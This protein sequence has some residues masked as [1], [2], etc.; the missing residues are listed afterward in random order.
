MT[1]NYPSDESC[2]RCGA[3]YLP[4]AAHQ[5][6]ASKIRAVQAETH[7]SKDEDEEVDEFGRIIHKQKNKDQ[8]PEWPP[9]FE[10]SG[11]VF[12]FD[13]RSGM[14]YHA[15]SE[16]FYDPKSKMYYGNKK[17]AYFRFD[18]TLDP[19]FEQVE[20][21]EGEHKSNLEAERALDP[22]PK[23]STKIEGKKGISIN[24]KTKSLK[25]KK[26]KTAKQESSAAA[27]AAA[28]NSKLQKKHAVD[29]DKWSDRQVEKRV[30]E[31]QI[32]RTAK[33]EPLCPLCRRKF[34][35]VE[36]L[37]HHERVSK[38][39]KENL[40]KMQ[41]QKETANA[42]DPKDYVDRAKQRRDMYGGPET[43]VPSVL[44]PTMPAPP[45]TKEAVP[46][47]PQS[48]LNETNIGNQLLQKMGWK[49]GKSLG[50]QGRPDGSS[51]TTLVKD[52]ERIEALA[53][54][55]GGRQPAGARNGGLGTHH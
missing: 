4:P 5:A 31:R 8:V 36:K 37:L 22:L 17:Q 2:D 34:P 30:E 14:F 53:A 10:S 23:L 41:Q 18:D 19:P 52:W 20:K 48:N 21:V 24:L 12:V 3:Y 29:M 7:D 26:P 1:W 42:T 50:R 9:K 11:S 46:S 28:A 43:S 13:S 47:V 55:N 39:H 32:Q 25:P 38:L 15:E 16:F 35:T 51:T 6:S 44:L 49:E 33:G 54:A 27:A 45:A 40:V